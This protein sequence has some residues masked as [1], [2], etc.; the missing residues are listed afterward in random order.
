MHLDEVSPAPVDDVGSSNPAVMKEES[1]PSAVEKPVPQPDYDVGPSTPVPKNE[2]LA[3]IAEK[4]APQSG[5]DVGSSTPT[6]KREEGPASVAEKPIPQSDTA[7]QS[8]PYGAAKPKRITVRAQ[9]THD[10]A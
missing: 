1:P 7:M 10:Q 9:I 8:A 5:Y 2:G 4:L 6:A 3:S